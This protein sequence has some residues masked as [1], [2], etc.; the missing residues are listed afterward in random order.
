MHRNVDFL[1]DGDSDWPWRGV[2]EFATPGRNRQR[3]QHVGGHTREGVKVTKRS[4]A[5]A[6]DHAKPQH[7]YV[8][9]S[10]LL[11]RRVG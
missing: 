7:Q 2:R 9:F 11:I 5:P 1:R 6:Q 8:V 4:R 10:L 3:E